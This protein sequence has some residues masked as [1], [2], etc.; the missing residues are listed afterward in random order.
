MENKLTIL[1]VSAYLP[2]DLW[3]KY[4]PKTSFTEN[5]KLLGIHTNNE[6]VYIG[7]S[8]IADGTNLS[9]VKPYL[10]PLSD[11]TKEIEHNGRKFIPIDWLENEYFN[12][13]LHEQAQTLVSDSRWLNHCNYLLIR[14]LLEWHFDIENLIERGLAIDLNTLS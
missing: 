12:L 4:F 6:Y 8:R 10:R 5:V 13:D 14:H 7:G 2:Y 1:E 9:Y 3:M 11:L